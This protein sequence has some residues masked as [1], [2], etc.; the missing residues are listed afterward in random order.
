MKTLLFILGLLTF[1]VNSAIAQKKIDFGLLYSSPL[2]KFC[3]DDYQDGGGLYFDFGY[4]TPLNEAWNLEFKTGFSW[5][6]NGKSSAELELGDY[7]LTNQFATWN[8]KFNIIRELGKWKPY[9]GL[10]AAYGAFMIKEKLDFDMIQEDGTTEY[11]NTLNADD[12]FLYGGQVGIYYQLSKSTDINFELG[13]MH[14]NREVQFINHETYTFDGEMLDYEESYSTPFLI[15]ATVGINFKI[16]A[17]LA[18]SNATT[19]PTSDTDYDSDYD[20]CPTRTRTSSGSSGGSSGSNN[21]KKSKPKLYKNGKT[22]V[23]Y[24]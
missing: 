14:G 22:P 9:A 17:T 4:I 5:S 13:V 10:Y 23:N 1:S 6:Q 8:F 24:Q 21:K 2:D 16:F 12:S 3:I 19:Y 11:L 18:S 20:Y 15:Q 7:D